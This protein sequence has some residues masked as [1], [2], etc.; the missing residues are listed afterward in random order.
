MK[1]IDLGCGTNMPEDQRIIIC[2]DCG[3]KLISKK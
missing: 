2:L 3:R 1:N